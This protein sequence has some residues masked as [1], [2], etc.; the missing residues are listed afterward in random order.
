MPPGGVH[1]ITPFLPFAADLDRKTGIDQLR[2]YP[3]PA[4][5]C[6][7]D[8]IWSASLMIDS[9]L[10]A[11]LATTVSILEPYDD[12]ALMR[13]YL[14]ALIARDKDFLEKNARPEVRCDS[15]FRL[16]HT[17]GL[18]E[19][20]VGAVL[21]KT[22]DC[23]VGAIMRGVGPLSYT[24]NWWC[25]YRDEP[26]GSPLEGASAVLSVRNGLVEIS[27]FGLSGPYAAAWPRR[28]N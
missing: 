26:D 17:S 2:T 6:S 9:I 18:L 13:S 23:D 16:R 25:K 7:I 5:P 8:V 19:S 11:A 21:E 4:N 24:V 14:A 22:K 10:V 1:P 28:S 12:E 15:Q 27:N 3:E 20:S